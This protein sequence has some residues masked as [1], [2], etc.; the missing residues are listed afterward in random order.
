[1][2]RRTFARS[3][4]SRT[5]RAKLETRAH[6]S[7]AYKHVTRQW[8]VSFNIKCQLVKADPGADCPNG[9]KILVLAQQLLQGPAVAAL[10]ANFPDAVRIRR[11]EGNLYCKP[12]NSTVAVSGAGTGCYNLVNDMANHNVY[13][14]MGLR[15]AQGA[16]VG[17][18]IPQALNPLNNGPDPFQLSDYSDGRWMKLW[19]H[20]WGSRGSVGSTL[21]NDFSC[22]STQ[23][24]YTVTVPPEAS[25]SQ[26]GYEY[27]VPPIVCEPCGDVENPAVNN[28]CNFVANTHDWWHCR[29]RHGRTIVLKENDDLGLYF[30]WE[31]LMDVADPARLVQPAMKFFGGLRLLI[32]S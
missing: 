17:A 27:T 2:A 22:C 10:G 16:Q 6:A 26:P 25:G 9:S 13:L 1:M 18:G 32:E 28:A 14:R 19:E 11:I 12:E 20:V 31:R 8:M 23:A 3:A 21:S 5:R 29:V 4:S 24:G 7:R 30:G 15:K